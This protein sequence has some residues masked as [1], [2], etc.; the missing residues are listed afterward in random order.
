MRGFVCLP[1]ATFLFFMT[2]IFSNASCVSGDDDEET[3]LPADHGDDTEPEPADDTE[4][5]PL[6][7]TEAVPSSGGASVSTP[8]T[9]HGSG[10]EEGLIVTVGGVEAESV[11][12]ESSSSA[13]VVFPPVPLTDLGKKNVRV[14]LG[15]EAASLHDG[16]EY[17][18]DED[19]IVFVHG[20]MVSSWE[21]DTMIGRFRDIGYPEEY[22]AAITFTSSLQSNVIN[23]RDELPG[24]VD[25]VLARTGAEKVDIIAHSA[26][27]I[28]SRLWIKLYGGGEKVRDYVSLSGT[29]HGTIMACFIPWLGQSSAETCP[30]YASESQSVND[31]QWLLNG[32]PDTDDVDETPFGVEDGG[33]IYWN[34][35]WTDGDIID[36]PPTTCCLNQKF[37]NDCSDPINVKFHGIGHIEMAYD[38]DV[39]QAAMEKVRAHNKN[40]P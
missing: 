37:R 32:N 26:G 16:F 20:Y 3:N 11:R 14:V 28:S 19:P 39:F 22:L 27:G 9:L 33:G 15:S 13:F 31:V 12:V 7:L 10:F 25:E 29:H 34:A 36:V 2:F 17:T 5:E 38:A 6:G 1:L 24:F 30:P 8:V 23:A 40:K 21:W 18:F 35:F 4:G